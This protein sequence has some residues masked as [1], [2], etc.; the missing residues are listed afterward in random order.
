MNATEI[1]AIYATRE[2]ATDMTR[3]AG[4][5]STEQLYMEKLDS[6]ARELQR[7]EVQ[8]RATRIDAERAALQR[9]VAVLRQ[10][11]EERAESLHCYR[12]DC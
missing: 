6:A 4:R 8:L 1:A 12:N 7:V 11:V 2:G 9:R 5:T 3:Y 10:H